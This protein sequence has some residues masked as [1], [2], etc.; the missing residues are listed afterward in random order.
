LK[1]P[2]ITENDLKVSE[3][4]YEQFYEVGGTW[5]KFMSDCTTPKIRGEKL[6]SNGF[7]KH[8]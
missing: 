2:E 5:K 3:K 8:S 4:M 7:A 6:F 1:N